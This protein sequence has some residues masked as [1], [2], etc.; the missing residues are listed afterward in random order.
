MGVYEVVAR[1]KKPKANRPTQRTP[2]AL[3]V[4]LLEDADV[5]SD[6]PPRVSSRRS[7]AKFLDDDARTGSRRRTGLFYDTALD[8]RF[9]E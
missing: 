6:P 5:R 4:A 2:A 1:C 9:R 7:P 8:V 3:L